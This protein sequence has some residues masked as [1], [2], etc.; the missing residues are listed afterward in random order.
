MTT[1]LEA[2]TVTTFALH[3]RWTT[4]KARD[5]YGYNRC[6]L[7]VDDAKAAACNGGGYDLKGTCFGNWVAETFPNELRQMGKKFYGLTWHDPDFD[8][9]KAVP[10]DAPCLGDETDKGKTVDQLEKEGKSAGL[11][12][13][14]Q[15][16]KA[17]NDTPTERHTV[18]LIDGACGFSCVQQIFKAIGGKLAQ[19]K[20]SGNHSYYEA[21]VPLSLPRQCD[22]GYRGPCTTCPTCVK[23]T[24]A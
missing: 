18:P 11:E 19:T 7:F 14:Q 10:A 3:F 6:T 4:S 24:T 2:P 9:G 22:C 21:T 16:Y 20:S 8:P 17:S 23:P 1:T 5:S 13:Y 15:F 12:R